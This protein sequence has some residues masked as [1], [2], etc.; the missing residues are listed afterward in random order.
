MILKKEK[1]KKMNLNPF[2]LVEPSPWPLSGSLALFI[3]TL[4]SVANWHG[5]SNSYISLLGFILL[6]IT[7][8]LWW[9]DT[10]REST[11]QGNHTKRVQQGIKIGFILFIISEIFFFL[12]IFWAFFHS[13]LIPSVELGSLWPPKGIEALNPWE[14]PLAN[15]F[16]LLTSGASL[17]WCHHNLIAKQNNTNIIL[18]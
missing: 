2:H 4:G 16:I 13:S 3:L 5:Y 10:I 1:S 15:T 14:V 11:L 7:M 8:G 9:R 6:L 17:T 12:S 18:K